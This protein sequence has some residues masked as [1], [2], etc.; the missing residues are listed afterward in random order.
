[1]THRI[2]AR[3]LT[4][5]A[6]RPF[7]DVIERVPG[8]SYPINGGRCDRY[9]DLARIEAAGDGARIGLSIG[10][11]QPAPLPLEVAFVERHPLGSQAFAPMTEDPFVVIVAPDEGGVPGAPLAFLTAPGQGVNYRRNTWHGVLTPLG[12]ASAFLILD[13]I[14]LGT[15]LEEHTYPKPWTVAVG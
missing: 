15:N 14:G 3:P 4:A 6:F 11:A 1:M 7:G 12:R 13:R 2:L 10:F 5:E 8:R 9:H